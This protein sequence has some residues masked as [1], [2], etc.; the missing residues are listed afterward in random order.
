MVSLS[1]HQASTNAGDK[2]VTYSYFLVGIRYLL[3]V[4]GIV[5]L[6]F[7]TQAEEVTNHVYPCSDLYTDTERRGCAAKELHKM[8]AELEKVYQELLTKIKAGP[9]YSDL[10]P[11]LWIRRSNWLFSL[12]H[13]NIGWL[14]VNLFVNF[15]PLGPEPGVFM[16]K[17]C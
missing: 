11:E 8:E 3:V 10:S 2:N 14:I 6:S 7:T 13:V 9:D 17:Y 16:T 4:F 12:P 15:R 1:S 5:F